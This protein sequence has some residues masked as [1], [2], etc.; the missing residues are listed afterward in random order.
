MKEEISEIICN[1]VNTYEQGIGKKSIDISEGI[2]QILALFKQEIIKKINQ[3]AATNADGALYDKA[4]DEIK[5]LIE[6]IE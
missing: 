4:I 3:L 2:D 6:S 1:V 5:K